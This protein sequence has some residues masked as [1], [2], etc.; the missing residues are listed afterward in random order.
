MVAQRKCTPLL[1]AG[2]AVT[3]I[4]P[5]ITSLLRKY[6]DKGLLT[7]I[8]RNYRKGDIGS[9]FMAIVATDSGETNQRV[10]SDAKAAWVLLNVVDVPGQC[11]FIMP[12]VLRRG[13]LTIAISTGG[14]SPALAKTVRKRLEGIYGSEIPRYLRFLKDTRTKVIGR[15]NDNRKRGRLLK[16]LASDKILKLLL[17]RGFEAAREAALRCLEKSNREEGFR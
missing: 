1:S 4:S 10:V 8:E 12:S 11:D 14:A 5:K 16:A 3:V 9:A 6:R 7:H 13:A 15:V 17:Q 2:A